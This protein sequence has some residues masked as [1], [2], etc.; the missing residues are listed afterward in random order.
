MHTPPADV[1]FATAFARLLSDRRL[2]A[3][4]RTDAVE[5]ARE[6]GLTGG[7]RT[8]WL[9]LDADDL[10]VQADGLI[11]KRMREVSRRL[12][13]TW[14]RLGGRTAARLFRMYAADHWPTGHRRHDEDALGFGRYLVDN[15]VPVVCEAELNQVQFRVAP[16]RLSVKFVRRA[17][18]AGGGRPAVQILYRRRGE[19]RS[20]L[21]FARS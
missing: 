2:R 3:R 12:S 20:L 9:S 10:D 6:L 11:Q 17:L 18:A 13:L 8:A 1:D 4:F 16:R 21:L 14:G 5:L 7:E 15:G 19:L